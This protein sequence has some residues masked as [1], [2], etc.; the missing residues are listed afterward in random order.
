[1]QLGVSLNPV[2]C[3]EMNIS[4]KYLIYIAYIQLHYMWITILIIPLTLEDIATFLSANLLPIMQI[5]MEQHL[6]YNTLKFVHAT[7]LLAHHFD[8]TR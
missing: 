4:V 8:I 2:S 3:K 6:N 7:Q 1:M 5:K